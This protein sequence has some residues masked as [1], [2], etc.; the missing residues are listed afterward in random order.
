[1]LAKLQELSFWIEIGIA[2]LVGAVL[3]ILVGYLLRLAGRRNEFSPAAL[4]IIRNLLRLVVAGIT[5]GLIFEQFGVNFMGFITATLAL[6]AIGFIAVWSMISN[7]TA[8]MLLLFV[9][10][11]KIGDWL[12]IP[13]E[14][15]SGEVANLDLFYTTLQKK[16][17]EEVKIPNNLLF[18]K[19]LVT[20]GGIATTELHE[21]LHAS[22]SEDDGDATK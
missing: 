15:V 11:F 14:N 20:R 16:S 6:V 9:K 2:V 17:G 3:F 22:Q 8:T 18:Q 7:I 13:S 5:L 12:E 4:R 19:I 10:P 21:A 1:M